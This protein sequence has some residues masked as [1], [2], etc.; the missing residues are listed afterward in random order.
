MRLPC[1]P[2]ARFMITT[3]INASRRTHA[4][5]SVEDPF[6]RLAHTDNA[7]HISRDFPVAPAIIR[8]SSSTSSAIWSTV[9]CVVAMSTAPTAGTAVPQA[10]ASRSVPSGSAKPHGVSRFAA[11][12]P[13][14]SAR[15][16]VN[17]NSTGSWNTRRLPVFGHA[18]DE[19]NAPDTKTK[20]PPL[21]LPLGTHPRHPCP[22]AF[23]LLGSPPPPGAGSAGH[24]CRAAFLAARLIKSG[25]V[26]RQITRQ[27]V[28]HYAPVKKE[29]LPLP[30]ASS[31]SKVI[32]LRSLVQ[33][34]RPLADCQPYARPTLDG[35]LKY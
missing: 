17:L 9:R 31:E 19:A 23:L 27:E 25:R 7:Q 26:R 6:G 10:I 33:H 16:P 15:A 13:A 32:P 5:C 22:G 8:C 12:N 30:I 11:N 28:I 20:V 24:R 4:I 2:L 18:A 29:R 14:P 34:S 35:A 3:G 1:A 21:D